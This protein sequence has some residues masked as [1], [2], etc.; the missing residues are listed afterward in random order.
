MGGD[1]VLGDLEGILTGVLK[2]LE[3]GAA[4]LQQFGKGLLF[5]GGGGILLF[6]HVRFLLCRGFKSRQS[7]AFYA[8]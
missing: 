8:F 6:S 3:L 4:D 1:V 5:L 7:R 2:L